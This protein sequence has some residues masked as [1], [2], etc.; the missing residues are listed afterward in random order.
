[1]G[2]DGI[3]RDT[4]NALEA[5]REL[6][7]APDQ[8][9]REV[10]GRLVREGADTRTIELEVARARQR[11]LFE[12]DPAHPLR[13]GDPP[14]GDSWDLVHERMLSNI[15]RAMEGRRIDG[16]RMTA[17]GLAPFLPNSQT[18]RAGVSSTQARKLLNKSPEEMTRAQALVTCEILGCTI[19]Y[20]RGLVDDPG[21]VYRTASEADLLS[22]YRS[23]SPEG[24]R[25][26]WRVIRALAVEEQAPAPDPLNPGSAAAARELAGPDGTYAD[27][28]GGE[29]IFF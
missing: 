16:R 15:E 10:R 19:D 18:G 5:A 14:G 7:P 13:H 1:M 20:L 21:Q 26:A 3:A 12:E 8:D 6:Y 11:P 17:S 23:L 27:A 2:L 22:A 24:R 25:T 9:A 28:N 4:L 29:I